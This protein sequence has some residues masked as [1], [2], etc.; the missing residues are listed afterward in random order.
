MREPQWCNPVR[1][2]LQAGELV[3]ALTVTTSNL[4]VAAL[5]ATLGFHFLWFEMQHL[6]ISLETLRNMVLATRGMP[7]FVFVRVPVVELWTA[8]RVFDQGVSGVIFPFTSMPELAQRAAQACN[9]PLTGLRGCGPG[10]AQTS[11][12]EP[13]C[14]HDSADRNVLVIAVIEEARAVDRID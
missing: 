5:G 8:K 10:L 2:R 11:W 4:E 7:G 6:P 1:S 14:Y 9:H 12:P 13:D 3:L